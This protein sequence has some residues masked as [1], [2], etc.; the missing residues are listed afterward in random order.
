MAIE[1]NGEID[2]GARSGILIHLFICGFLGFSINTLILFI[3]VQKL[4]RRNAHVDIKLCTFV[5]ATDVVVSLCLIF[6]SIFTKY[7][8][9]LIQDSQGWCKFDVLTGSQVL[10]FSGYTLGVMSI[11][12]FLLICFN[13]QLSFAFWLVLIILTWIPQYIMA[14]IGIA[15]DIQ[16]LVKIRVYC[17]VP[18]KGVGYGVFLFATVMFITSFLSVLISYFGIM[19]VKYKQCLN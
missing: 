16:V 3:L 8:F 7:P 6:R 4:R 10:L 14:S 5:A 18:P 13:R 11:E 9:N 12:R 2:E 17:T 19:I 15:N 1:L